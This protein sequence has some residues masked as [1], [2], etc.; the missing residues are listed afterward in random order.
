M[1]IVAF[2]VGFLLCSG[3]WAQALTQTD[4]NRPFSPELEAGLKAIDRKHYATALRAFRPQGD[5]GEARAQNNLGFMYE[6]GMGVTQSYVEAMNWYRK[7]ADQGLPEAQF[8]VAS[9]YHNG[10]GV[11]VN[12][13]QAVFWLKKAAAQELPDALYLLAV[14]HLEGKGTRQDLIA[15]K[16]HFLRAARK[17][18]V[19]AQFMS[20]YLMLNEEAGKPDLV[21]AHAWLLVSQMNGFAGQG[22]DD[23]LAFT[24]HRLKQPQIDLAS[25]MARRCRSSAYSDCPR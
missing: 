16:S 19:G 20:A 5:A 2:V 17:A 4:P 13:S 10:Y 9:L 11:E 3:A 24:S 6:R 12:N 1:R 22:L 8:N 14:H 18:H 7:A 25:A 23:L 21:G 15:A